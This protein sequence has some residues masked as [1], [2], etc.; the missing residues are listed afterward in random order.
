MAEPTNRERRLKAHEA[1][2]RCKTCKGTTDKTKLCAN[3]KILDDLLDSLREV[4]PS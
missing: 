3:C 1:I 2:C 4:V